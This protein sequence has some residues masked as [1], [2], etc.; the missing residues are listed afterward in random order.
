MTHWQPNASK[1]PYVEEM[2]F[3]GLS[4]SVLSGG[5]SLWVVSQL[6]GRADC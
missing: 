6:F 2:T 1:R 3:N 5:E 4:E